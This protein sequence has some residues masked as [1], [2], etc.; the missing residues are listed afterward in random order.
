MDRN[1]PGRRL[2]LDRYLASLTQRHRLLDERIEHE[3]RLASAPRRKRLKRLK[4]ALKD[5][6]AALGRTG[7]PA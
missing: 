5:R 6:I 4:L 3:A 7:Q 2:G 1:S